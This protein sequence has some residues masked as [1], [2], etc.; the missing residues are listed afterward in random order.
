MRRF[1]GL[2]DWL[3][4]GFD[5]PAD[6]A[7]ASEEVRGR[8]R[9]RQVE[10]ITRLTPAIMTANIFNALAMVF[11]FAASGQPVA[12][13]ALWALVAVGAAAWFLIGWMRRRGRPFPAALGPATSR[14][15]VRNAA[16][17]AAIWAAPVAALMPSAAPFPQAFLL[18]VS[19]GMV[20]GGVTCFY[21]VPRAAAAYSGI[22]VAAAVIGAAQSD[23]AVL[24]GGLMVVASYVFVVRRVIARHSEIFVSE[25]VAR[26]ELEEKNRRIETLMARTEAEAGRIARESAQR[27]ERA[28]KMEAVGQL[29]G[30]MAHDFN[31]ILSVIRGNAEL[32]AET[33]G[34]DAAL[35][36]EI[37]AATERGADVI[38]K[39][40]AFSRRQ[41][42]RPEPT[43]VAGVVA[44]LA[45]MLERLLT[46]RV[47]C[48]IAPAP[49]L[50]S[51]LADRA[52]LQA[53]L[54]N[55]ALNARDAMPGGGRLRISCANRGVGADEAATLAERLGHEVAPGDYVSVTVRD[56]GVGMSP[57]VAARAFEPF[58]TTK[59]VGMG[60]GL[61]LS[62]VLGFIRQ[63]GGFV[64]L[65]SVEGR[66]AA[67]TLC[68]QRAAGAE[69]MPQARDMHDSPRGTGELVLL[70]EDR[71]DVRRTLAG[72]IRGLG[73]TVAEAEDVGAA[74]ALMTGGLGAR[75]ILSDVVLPGGASGFDLR[76]AAAD[77]PGWPP[78]LLM[79]GFPDIA[80]GG[81]SASAPADLLRKP[82]SRAALAQALRDALSAAY[83]ASGPD[84]NN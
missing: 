26:L 47:R 31:N 52:Q 6:H 37:I 74:T 14:K 45:P 57:E 75:V 73:Y 51:A 27:L 49:G 50:W 16:L 54:V 22:L 71:G 65:D 18:L 61:G 41:A 8:I 10:A 32:Q 59:P 44:D 2:L 67:V 76:A 23:F 77:R 83:G 3:A 60:S 48:E 7:D 33:P 17:M 28:Q 40:L 79:S 29:T 9:A 38:Q 25:I 56:E 36:G 68:L 55:L 66:G 5:D 24:V 81:M 70:V 4:R 63:S 69:T 58:F 11:V 34:K 21:P 64:L 13:I 19:A 72:M 39:L 35:I 20:S 46:E 62:M 84:R 80:D 82:F 78:V 12:P 42:L 30:G 1:D 15:V 53:A 43:D